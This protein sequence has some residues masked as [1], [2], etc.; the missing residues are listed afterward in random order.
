MLF[1]IAI[2]AIVKPNDSNAQAT[3][4][5]LSFDGSNDYVAV[6]NPFTAFQKEITV[7]WWVYIVPGN[8]YTLGSG[9]GQG[10]VGTDN[11]S[12][13]V[14]LMHFNGNGSSLQFYVNDAGVWR[15]HS[16]VNIPSGW[17]HIAGVADAN[18]TRLFVDG[19]QAGSTG[20]GI[21]TGIWSN[22]NAKM[23]FGKDVRFN[24]N[25][26]MPGI[27]DEIRIWSRA[28]CQGEL[29]NNKFCEIP[30][31]AP[32]L[33]GNY[34][35][36]QGLA[37]GNNSTVITLFDASGNGRH[38]T[39][40]NM[41]L[42]GST[43]NWVTP[44]GIVNGTV[45]AP[46]AYP[47]ASIS[48]EG[49]TTFC[50]GESVTLSANTNP[51]FTYQWKK[52]NIN[53]SGATNSIYAAT[54]SGN[55]T[56]EITNLGCSSISN[57]ITVNVYTADADGDGIADVC[58]S[59][60][61]ND[62]I[63]DA[64]ECTQSNF[65]WS[66]P[67]TYSG[68]VATGT[69]NGI[70]YT[71]TSSSPIE[72]TT[73]VFAH[74][75]FPTS[76]AVPNVN[77]TIKNTQVTTNTL[78]FAQPM[79]N[80]VL[81]FASIGGINSVP[82]TFSSPIDVLWSKDVTIN[83]TTQITGK[84]G[85]AI[86]RLNGTYSSISFNYL[87]AENWCNFA[88]G[89]D[90]RVCLDTDNDGI[91]NERDIDSDNDGCADA[92]EATPGYSIGQTTNGSLNGGVNAQGIPL[93]AGNGQTIGTSQ[94]AVENCFC[95]ANVDKTLPTALAKNISI[96]LTNANPV[97]ITAA[98]LD[99]GSN[100]ACGIQSITISKSSFGCSDVGSN[101]VTLT[102]TDNNGN[103]STATAVV[104][105][106]ATDTD[107]DGVY[108][109]CDLD[110]DNDG[111]LDVTECNKSNF[112][113]SNAP[114]FLFGRA[115]GTIN[116]INYSY[117]STAP[118]ESTPSVYNHGAFPS[119]YGVPN[120]SPTIKNTQAS[121]NTLTFA[122]P[123]KNPVLVFASI[124]NGNTYVPIRFSAAVQ[125]LW[126]Q[127]VVQ[128]SPTQITGNEG[129]AIVRLNGTY[130]SIT[131]DYLAAENWCNFAFGA[132]FTTCGDTDGDGTPDYAD[133]D[134]DND[135]CSD[136]IE[137]SAGFLLT[138]TTNNKLI[139]A[140]NAQGV[141]LLAG[142]GQ[143]NGSSQTSSANC[144]CQPNIDRTL[145]VVKTKNVTV[146]LN[147][148]GSVSITP[149]LI[150]DGSSDAC[151]IKTYTL[152]NSIFNCNNLGQNTVT[153]TVTDV[154]GNVATG[155]AIVT[156]V[157]NIA[158]TISCGAN[159]NAIATSASGSVVNY[160]MPTFG[161]NCAASISLESGLIS[162]STFPIGTTTVVYKVTDLSGNSKTCSFNVTVTGIAPVIVSPGNITV[163]T[164]AALCSGIANYTAT[165]TTGIPASTITYS[166][167]PGST[168]NLGTTAV[169]ATAT[170]A[171]GTSSVTFNVT[172]VD[173][174]NPTITCG[175]DIN[176]Y[177]TSAAGAVVNYAMPTY[178]D[179]CS[180]TL[181]LESGLASGSTFPI[182]TTAVTY[183]VT[184]A[185][186][187]I[188]TCSFDVTVT[189]I[190]PVIVSPGDITVNTSTGLCS[191]IANY[192]ATETTGIPASTITYSIVP[193]STFNVGTTTVTATATNAVGTSS[194]TF[195]VI[196]VD[197]ENPTAIAQNVTVNLANG[198]ASVTAAQIN[199]GSNDACGIASM[200]LDKSTFDCSNIGENAVVLTVT[201]V[202]GN[203]STANAIVNVQGFISTCSISATANNS[204]TVIGG[205]YTGAV[206]NQ[207][208]IGYGAQ[209][210]NIVC[211]AV[212]GGPFTYKWY[213]DGLNNVNIAN[214]IFTPTTAG[215]YTLMCEVTNSSGCVTYCSIEICVF[216]VR[217]AGGSAKN[218]KV[219]LCHVPPGNSNNPQTLNISV[220]AV[221]SHLGNH[222]GD[223][224][225]S[226]NM[227]CGA[228]VNAN[229]E[230]DIYTFEN[231][232]EDIDLVVYPN[233][234]TNK[235]TFILESESTEE[236]SISI[237]DI[238]GRKVLE[239][240]KQSANERIELGEELI[241]GSYLAEV[242]QGSN[243][244]TIKIIKLN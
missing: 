45:C 236:V 212:T 213:G 46:F 26:F 3:G 181:T 195:N 201:D 85:Y 64:L 96:T 29:Q 155:T 108:D 59:D 238:A 205:T 198:T 86:I 7:E 174:I 203:V 132:D 40:T 111:I 16:A 4:S 97:N 149:A 95:Q 222:A 28:I 82:I 164:S 23:H 159:I 49:S 74:S 140:V 241:A 218:P 18:A 101:N 197:A 127:N 126:S 106:V 157:D 224:L 122:Q 169:T 182:G 235:F 90:F 34:H 54:T 114:F 9:I 81:V 71:Y 175:A 196:V 189:G 68:N 123:M 43:S 208:F 21:S 61:D 66:N 75:Q 240:T 207:M 63:P 15:T 6:N 38:G 158:P 62:G 112:Y 50:M 179:N 204:G 237:F 107:A 44:G 102:V 56:V 10:T 31:A 76:Y 37:E 125:I 188:A 191:G 65:Y 154:N 39:L 230:G 5:A 234:S 135:G 206:P 165:E 48:P 232:T 142:A 109:P 229:A 52:N 57:A 70:A 228:D 146:A 231:A 193:G 20:P 176:V 91:T 209:S 69:I 219:Y 84:E 160:A 138:Q 92:I 217:A 223:R 131:F 145:P 104:T 166:I 128:N 25:R 156:V 116:G 144:F 87:A 210:M 141:P 221:P 183:K 130:S 79:T 113:W 172:V 173:N 184:D 19:V 115:Y 194:T 226:C 133:L 211:T 147:S 185:A 22:P 136:A 163:N 137:G 32:N 94:S 161:D 27:M 118:L 124:G 13:N 199:N 192:T 202:N 42:T 88:F 53:I 55:Y 180:A 36:N 117:S 215:N 168:F 242:T 12:N 143:S 186:G 110:D 1:L 170:N 152:N 153:L 41:A 151:G 167:A 60:D 77:P 129:Y 227:V 14:W 187:N 72:V 177:A 233:P 93:L 78:T 190:P 24:S 220:N 67:P 89:A 200:T 2:F 100:D 8:T 105:I 58:D 148:T 214:P 120:V 35:F 80:P 83:S 162:G 33:E 47:N 216:D 150:N 225:G 243:R 98:Q 119:S 30:G 239:L 171:V 244:K 103:V 11:M 73:N 17:H 139:G 134:S 178:A 121:T 51:N 99:N